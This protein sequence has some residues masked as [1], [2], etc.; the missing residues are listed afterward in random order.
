MSGLNMAVRGLCGVLVVAV[1]LVYGQGRSWAASGQVA[2]L[3]MKRVLSTSTA[4]K[5]AQTLLENKA[6]TYQTSLQKDE[7]SL[8][9]LQQEMEKK[10]SAWSDSVKQQKATE[11]QQKRRA[12]AT[13]QEKAAQDMKTLRDEQL[14][15]ILIKLE[16]IVSKIASKKGYSVVLP[17]NVVLYAADASD[18][19]NEVIAELNKTMK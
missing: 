14:N 2:V 8:V 18:I 5:R 6:K 3:D 1:V 17:R 7:T 12:L 19:T 13:Q 11:F 15:P 4:G 10:G 16:S 9:N